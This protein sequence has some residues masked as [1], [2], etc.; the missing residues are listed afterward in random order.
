MY[1]KPLVYLAGYRHHVG[2]YAFP[3][4]HEAFKQELSSYKHGKGSV[5]FPFDQSLP[6]DLIVKLVHFRIEE[7][8][9]SIQNKK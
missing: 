8:R 5:Q 4:V 6:T 3:T 7:N 2:F 1:G 9:L